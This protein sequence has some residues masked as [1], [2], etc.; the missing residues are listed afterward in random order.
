[1]FNWDILMFGY[2]DDLDNEEKGEG[3]GGEDKDEG[4]QCQEVGEE[5]RT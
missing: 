5:A 1:M 2:L 3:E 4:A